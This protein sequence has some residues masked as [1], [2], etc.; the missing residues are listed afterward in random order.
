MKKI[1]LLTV[2]ATGLWLLASSKAV[3][4]DNVY[5]MRI[6]IIIEDPSV[7]LSIKGQYAIETLQNH[8]VLLESKDSLEETEVFPT[9][10]GVKIGQNDFN[11]Y[12]IR[13]LPTVGANI[14]INKKKYR[15]IVDIIR[16][17]NMKLTVVN[18]V[19]IEEY[20]YGVLYHEVPHDW[21]METLMAQA[22]AARTYAV[23]RKTKLPNKDYDLTND[24]Y[25]QM[26]G[27]KEGERWR[28]KWAINM[29]KGK[30]L[31]YKGEILP[32]FYSSCCGG[33]TENADFVWGI[34]LKPLKGR[35]CS[36]CKE[37]PYYNWKASFSFQQIE[38]K[39]NKTD[40]KCA[41]I[42]WVKVKD[43]DNSGRPK[44]I[45]VTDK[46]G[47]KNIPADKFRLALGGYEFL[48]STK[49]KIDID[50]TKG[51]FFNGHGWG[52]GVGMCQWGAKGLADKGYEHDKILAF[53][54]PEAVIEK[55]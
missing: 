3:A 52:H 15:G 24:Q 8:E 37:S 17:K 28:G 7:S 33:H 48:K 42:K 16:T 9:N 34:D 29:T 23:Y 49:F 44:F 45:T 14:E 46:K 32:A 50:M 2:L 27:G 35:A 41:G 38:E 51:V 47:D 19:D 43:V 25:S 36:Y 39:L 30:V 40:F 55:I 6:R 21:P 18:H 13:I 20:L 54:Y 22:I 53:Y 12:G 4:Q 5:Y 10:A 26:Y 11:V 31:K 1:L